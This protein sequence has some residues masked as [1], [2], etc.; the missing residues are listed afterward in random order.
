MATKMHIVDNI[1]ATTWQ[2]EKIFSFFFSEFGV[3][4]EKRY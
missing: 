4:I 2:P 1:L 3:E